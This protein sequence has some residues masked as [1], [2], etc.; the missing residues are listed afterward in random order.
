M[1]VP[2]RKL[3]EKNAHLKEDLER[4]RIA[5]A[6]MNRAIDAI[7]VETARA[8]GAKRPDGEL[9][10]ELDPVRVAVLEEYEVFARKTKRGGFRVIV[11]KRT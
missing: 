4:S 5:V 8:Y 2:E 11:R 6:E 9:V 7:L 1:T 10:L 3:M